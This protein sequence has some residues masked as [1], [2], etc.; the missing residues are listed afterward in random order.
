MALESR[1]S[2]VARTHWRGS[3]SSCSIPKAFGVIAS[4][5]KFAGTL[6]VE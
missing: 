6:R 3:R 2:L 1:L 5:G 4:R